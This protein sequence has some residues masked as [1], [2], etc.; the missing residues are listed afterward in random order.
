[1]LKRKKCKDKVKKEEEITATKVNN[2]CS[3]LPDG[4]K[5]NLCSFMKADSYPLKKICIAQ[6]KHLIKAL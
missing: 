1:M 6:V 5:I 2:M 4:A 3:S